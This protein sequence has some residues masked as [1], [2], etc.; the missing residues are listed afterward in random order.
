M[1]TGARPWTFLARFD[2]TFQVRRTFEPESIRVQREFERGERVRSRLSRS[3]RREVPRTGWDV[4]VNLVAARL[5]PLRMVFDRRFC[6]FS[7][8]SVLLERFRLLSFA[9]RRTELRRRRL[10]PRSARQRMGCAP[11]PSPALRSVPMRRH[12]ATAPCLSSVRPRRGASLPSSRSTRPS[13][14]S[15]RSSS[16][17]CTAWIWDGDP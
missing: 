17:T 12:A 10:R 15:C 8:C 16:R 4:V 1:P 7:K 2:A 3:G 13:T 14:S 11:P 9:D 5:S 6:R